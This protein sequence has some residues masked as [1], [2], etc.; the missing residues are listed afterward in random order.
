MIAFIIIVAVLGLLLSIASNASATRRSQER[1]EESARDAAR[2]EA[3][4][5]KGMPASVQAKLAAGDKIGAIKDYRREMDC[6]LAEALKDI[7]EFQAT[8]PSR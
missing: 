8:A 4:Q 1:M 5:K 6:G 2:K 3:R 7:E